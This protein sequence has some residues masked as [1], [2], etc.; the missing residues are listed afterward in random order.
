MKAQEH[1]QIA[2]L[3]KFARSGDRSHSPF[4]TG[5]EEILSLVTEH[6]QEALELAREGKACRET[7][8]CS[9]ALRAQARRQS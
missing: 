5:R 9:K 2:A 8:S 4:F 3:K 7:R 6:C 1:P